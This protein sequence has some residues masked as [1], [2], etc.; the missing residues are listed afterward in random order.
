MLAA[1]PLDYSSQRAL[2]KAG[3]RPPPASANSAADRRERLPSA[4]QS[5]GRG[6]G[7]SSA[8]FPCVIL[9][10][11][12][13]SVRDERPRLRPQ[14]WLLVSGSQVPREVS[15][16]QVGAGCKV[17]GDAVASGATLPGS[18][19]AAKLTR[20][21]E[22]RSF[23]QL[24]GRRGALGGRSR[25]ACRA[26]RA[27][28]RRAPPALLRAGVFR[29]LRAVPPAPQLPATCS[30]SAP[31]GC[32]GGGAGHLCDNSNFSWGFPTASWVTLRN[33]CETL[34]FYR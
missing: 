11:A 7:P 5:P 21:P 2:R 22:S 30:R 26:S 18:H 15:P 12:S 28:G 31:P 6:G 9:P 25:R 14:P 23:A 13:G 27:S 1:V 24:G 33:P 19:T 32:R 17:A 34:C 3:R 29:A 10:S 4:S 16:R 8:V 20:A